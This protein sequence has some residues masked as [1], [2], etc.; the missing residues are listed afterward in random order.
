MEA[1][2]NGS[3]K[4][5]DV[6]A[7]GPHIYIPAE[8]KYKEAPGMITEFPREMFHETLGCKAANSKEEMTALES[9]GYRKQAYPAKPV[10]AES[11]AVGV[12]LSLMILQQQQQMQKQNEI[13]EKQGK[14]LEALM[15]A[16]TK[17]D[18]AA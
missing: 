12:D 15:A 2:L 1:I 7:R 16:K 6:I 11:A 4:P 3:E 8:H 14:Q 17:K 10:A 5:A 9:Q 18:S 13:I